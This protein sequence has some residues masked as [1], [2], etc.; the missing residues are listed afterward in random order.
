MIGQH[1]QVKVVEI[2]LE[3]QKIGLSIRALIAPA[4]EE[5][6]ESD[7]AAVEAETVAESEVPAEEIVSEPENNEEAAAEETPA[8]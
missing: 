3:N 1:V 7:E 2:D 8:E 6:A 4:N 5:T